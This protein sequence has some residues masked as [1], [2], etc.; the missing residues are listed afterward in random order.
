MIGD[1]TSQISNCLSNRAIAWL[2]KIYNV[3]LKLIFFFIFS[4]FVL[5]FD[6]PFYGP[7]P[8]HRAEKSDQDI[9]L[10]K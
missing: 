10:F 1:S 5:E 6:S 3:M 2:Q 8:F 7:N 4:C 9:Y